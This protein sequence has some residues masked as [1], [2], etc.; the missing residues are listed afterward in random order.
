M[1]TLSISLLGGFTVLRAGE[2]VTTFGYDKVRALLAFLAVEAGRPHRRDRLAA[3][4]W[5][6]QPR[7][8]ALQSLS[9]ALYQLRRVLGDEAV[10]AGGVVP[11][12]L[13]TPQT[14]QFNLAADFSF[15][16]GGTGRLLHK[17]RFSEEV[18]YGEDQKVS[19]LSS[20]FELMDRLVPNFLGVISPQKIRGTRVLLR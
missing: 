14:V 20:Y 2:P 12:L 18:L 8:P 4:L 10:R 7:S 9:Q 1:N 6:E 19:P 15:I 3:L 16:D 5:P 17:E 13:V 11:L